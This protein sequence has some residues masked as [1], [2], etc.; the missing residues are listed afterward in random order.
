M[1]VILKAEWG[2]LTKVCSALPEAI[3]RAELQNMGQAARPAVD[4]TP[5]S[6]GRRL[7]YI[8]DAEMG[9]LD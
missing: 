4:E 3:R 6:I 2:C 8:M 9:F 1:S 7:K 5:N